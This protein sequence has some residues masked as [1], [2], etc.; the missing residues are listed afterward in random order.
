MGYIQTRLVGYVHLVI[1]WLN[2]AKTHNKDCRGS[3]SSQKVENS[4]YDSDRHIKTVY[5]NYVEKL[6]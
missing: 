4:V 2:P 1:A 5:S 6:T 3:K